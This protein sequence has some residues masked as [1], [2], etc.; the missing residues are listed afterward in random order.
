MLDRRSDYPSLTPEMKLVRTK[1]MR[2][3]LL[4][5]LIP[6][7]LMMFAACTG[8]SDGVDAG[9]PEGEV[10]PLLFEDLS[11][12]RDF[13]FYTPDQSRPMRTMVLVHG[14]SQTA[15]EIFQ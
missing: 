3:N 9:N 2:Q 10:G 8:G 14:C 15:A 4:H 12:E 7:C 6:L 1:P 11:G 13:M 5:C